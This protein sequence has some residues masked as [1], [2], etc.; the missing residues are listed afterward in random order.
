LIDKVT[1][2]EIKVE[3]MSDDAKRANVARE[4]SLLAGW[5]SYVPSRR[6]SPS[7]GPP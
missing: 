1:I 2:L 4:L 7:C 5:P 3:R 6:R